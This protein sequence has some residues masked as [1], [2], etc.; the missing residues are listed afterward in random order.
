[1]LTCC[2]QQNRLYFFHMKHKQMGS[3]YTFPKLES[4][5]TLLPCHP[6]IAYLREEKYIF[7]QKNSQ[8]S[9]V[10]YGSYSKVTII[11]LFLEVVLRS[12]K[13]K[14][15]NLDMPLRIVMSC[16][17]WKQPVK[18]NSGSECNVKLLNKKPK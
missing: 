5:E 4:Q 17:I 14:W 12:G 8:L 3:T 1:M 15:N 18:M 10:L 13:F 6:Q 7:I 16:I 11:M 2:S 9:C